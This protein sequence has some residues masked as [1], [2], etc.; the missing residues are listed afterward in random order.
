MS[1]T[2]PKPFT[3]ESVTN[4]STIRKRG[5]FPFIEK[6]IRNSAVDDLVSSSSVKSIPN[7]SD[8]SQNEPNIISK[9]SSSLATHDNLRSHKNLSTITFISDKGTAVNCSSCDKE[10][11]DRGKNQSGLP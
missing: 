11:V 10:I 1:N 3:A 6:L 5:R 7:K 8:S 4:E 9:S 2:L